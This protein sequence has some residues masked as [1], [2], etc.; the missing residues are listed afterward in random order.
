MK[1][2]LPYNVMRH[3]DWDVAPR[4]PVS[5]AVATFV[6]GATAG[7]TYTAVY[8][9]TTIAIT[10]VTSW[11]VSALTPKPDFSSLNSGGIMVNAREATSPHDFVYG[12]VRKGGI[13]TYYETTGTNNKFLHQI[14]TLAGHEVEE[15]GDIYINDEV[16][17]LD[18]DGFV[19]GDKWKSK[20]RVQKFDGTQTAAPADLLN[21]SSQIDANFVGRGIAYLYVRYEY[22]QDV[23][24]NGVPLVTAVIKGKKVFDPRDNTTAYSNNAVLCLRDYLTAEYGLDDDDIDETVFAAA[25]NICDEPVDLD[26][27]GT[28]PR[29]TMN[30]VTKA[31]VSHGDVLNRMVTSCAG[32]LFWGAGL[33]KLT[34]GAYTA[35]TKTLTLDDLRSAI[36]LD[37]RTNLRDQFNIVQGTFNDASQRWI[38][39]DYPQIRG[40]GFITEDNDVEQALDFELPLTTSAATAQRLAKLTLFRGR[41][42]MT[43]SADFGL[44]A[45][46]V[47]VGEIIALDIDRYGWSNK[48]FEVTG[49]RFGPSAEGDTRVTLTLRETSAEAFQWDAEESVIIANN[50]NLL[51]Y[52]DIP[53]LGIPANDIIPS[54][55]IVRE[56][57]TEVISLNITTGRPEAV[58][59]VEVQFAEAGTNDWKALGSGTLGRYELVDPEPGSYKFRARA[60]NSFGYFGDYTESGS[61]QTAGSAE[62]PSD[63][64]GLFYEISD[65]TTTLE[66]EPV[67]DLD[68]SFYRVRH[69]VETTGATWA[70]ATTAVDK[71]PRPGTSVAL[72]T[73]PGT[74]LI[75]AYDKTGIASQNASSVVVPVDE[76]PAFAQSLTQ[77]EHPAFAGAKTDCEV[78]GGSL[79]ITDTSTAPSEATYDFSTYIETHDATARRV[80]ARVDALSFRIDD[81]A[82]LFDDLPGLFDD[83]PGL[84]D[85]TTG[86][87]QFSDTSLL[88]YI[89]TTNDDPAGVPTWSP[90]K[91]FRSGDFYGRAFRFRVVL[92]STSANVTPAIS[93]LTAFVEYN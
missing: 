24:A 30:G 58:D 32:T 14:I 61:V 90:Y 76:V 15:I 27:G 85:D 80:R 54:I 19:T 33:W 46:D 4:D 83:L 3:R 67:P 63:V 92:K 57:I 28:E 78:S 41:E 69:S 47:E 40:D 65:G 26:G 81:G 45:F 20:I 44:N 49:W 72:P 25:A 68:L 74:Y 31:N 18:G 89:S 16:V 75:K 73:R 52:T 17:S 35:P 5:A 48:E 56:K 7:F 29:Y 93:E 53:T 2:R 11:A 71:V 21:E 59:R 51:S 64:E 1:F 66:W 82:G 62:P 9:A 34:A 79:Q 84:F 55:R 91:Q 38:T 43:L 10:A 37:T 86:A 8:I 36:N 22:D 87:A 39:A 23:F 6:T 42:Q 77:V 50:T 70:N 88:F 60:I 13:V 12:E